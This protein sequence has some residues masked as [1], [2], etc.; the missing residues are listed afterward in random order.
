MGFLR[1]WHQRL[2]PV[3]QDTEENLKGDRGV[4][5]LHMAHNQVS[6]SKIRNAITNRPSWSFLPFGLCCL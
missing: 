3:V 4:C 6:L 5:E 1:S 2:G